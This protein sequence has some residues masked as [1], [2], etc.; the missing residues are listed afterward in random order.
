MTRM[1]MPPR[2]LQTRAQQRALELLANGPQWAKWILALPTPERPN[3]EQ[4]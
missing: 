2:Q 4:P 1:H 3:T